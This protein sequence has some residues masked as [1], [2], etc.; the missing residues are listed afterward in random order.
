[1]TEYEYTVTRPAAGVSYEY[2]RSGEFR[3]GRPVFR[4]TNE[5]KRKKCFLLCVSEESGGTW[6]T[7]NSLC[8]FDSYSAP[9]CPLGVTINTRRHSYKFS[10]CQ[11]TKCSAHQ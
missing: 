6:F 2:N 11:V 1:M 10:R 9:C 8:Y 5:F 3:L 4:P 7:E